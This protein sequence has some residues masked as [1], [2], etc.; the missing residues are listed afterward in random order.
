MGRRGNGFG[1]L[2][3][4]GEG[5]PYMAKWMFKG[6]LHFKTTGE[7][8][9][10]K[11]LKV[12]EKLTRPYRETSV[13][14]VIANLENE[15]KK[16][17]RAKAPKQLMVRDLWNVFEA[18][19]WQGDVSEGTMR[20][21][22]NGAE[23]MANWMRIK[24]SFVHEISPKLCEAYLK[25]LSASVGA[26]TFNLRLSLFKRMWKTLSSEYGLDAEL[27]SD[28]KKHKSQKS[29]RRT[30]SS[31]ELKAVME[32]AETPSMKLLLALGIYTGLRLSDCALLKWESVDI[33]G[34]KLSVVPIKTK[35]HC[36]AVE[37][38]M[39]PV[40]QKLIE[41]MPHDG[42][43][44]S[45]EN[46]E[47]Y[48]HGHLSGKVV[49]LFKKCGIETSRKDENG[50]RKLVCGFH[51]LRHTFV[52]MAIN[53]GMSPLLVQRIVGHRTVDMTSAYFH[54]N[55]EIAAEGI[56]KLPDYACCS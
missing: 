30:L 39:H 48:L 14:D 55:A 20:V 25:E 47:D 23:H 32:K 19:T 21:Y 44:V 51:S 8:D 36:G 28:F 2:V 18:K 43:Y 9:R 17:K 45:E 3:S 13:D 4:K 53:N 5:K 26:V 54:E 41:E 31:E 49:E 37:I 1:T 10:K 52:S 46:A 38:P 22:K 7:T 40:L 34:K 12:L 15:L 27:W 33:E 35:K 11:A 24:V 56:A 42:E 16:L 29:T 50:K 6:E